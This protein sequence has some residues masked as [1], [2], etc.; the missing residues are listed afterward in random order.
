V[1]DEAAHENMALLVSEIEGE[2]DGGASSSR[3]R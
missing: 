1:I 3:R 2:A